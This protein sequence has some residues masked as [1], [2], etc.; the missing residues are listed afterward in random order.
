VAFVKV[1]INPLT[2]ELVRAE[3]AAL[4]RLEKARLTG[5][6]VPRV[7]MHEQWRGL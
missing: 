6:G 1:G 4:A 3:R 7:L 5:I 2:R